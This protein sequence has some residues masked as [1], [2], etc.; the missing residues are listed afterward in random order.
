M[1]AAGD[2]IVARA[3]G[4]GAREHGRLDFDEAHFVH[5]FADFKDDFVAQRDIAVRLGAAEIDIAI[6]QAGFFGGVDF[7]FYGE[8]RSFRVVENMQFSGD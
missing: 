8:G 7:I 4:R 6:A 3:F 2:E 1:H 5:D